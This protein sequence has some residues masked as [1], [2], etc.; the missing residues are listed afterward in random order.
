MTLL[1]ERPEI[2]EPIVRELVTTHSVKRGIGSWRL[3][4]RL[5][6]REVRH[7]WGR[8]IIVVLLIAVPVAGMTLAGGSYRA[9]RTSSANSRLLGAADARLDFSEIAYPPTDVDFRP[10]VEQALPEGTEALWIDSAFV[11]LRRD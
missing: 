5:A 9:N 7:R 1:D 2:D 11:L 3:A 8:T 10:I 4:A 6:R